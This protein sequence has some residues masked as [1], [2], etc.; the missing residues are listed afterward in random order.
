MHCFDMAFSFVFGVD[1]DIILIHNDKNMELFRKNFMNIALKCC[2]SV[3]QSKRH[4]LI[5]EVTV[6]GAKNSFPLIFF[7]NFYLV[8]GTGE[9]KLGKLPSLP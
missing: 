9:V 8:I 4:Y 5:F 7:A 6:F 2:Q 3:D 1:K